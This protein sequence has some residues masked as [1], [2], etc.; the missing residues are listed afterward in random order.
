M[1]QK[2]IRCGAPGL[3]AETQKQAQACGKS[4]LWSDK[5]LGSNLSPAALRALGELEH[6]LSTIFVASAGATGVGD[7]SST[8]D[9]LAFGGLAVVALAILPVM[10][11]IR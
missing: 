2:N 11:A 6:T 8:L 5:T 10:H 9:Q 3:D 7:G 1:S 4:L